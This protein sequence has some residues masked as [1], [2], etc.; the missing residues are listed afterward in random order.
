MGMEN[1]KSVAIDIDTWQILTD[2]AEQECRS[3]AMQIKWLVRNSSYGRATPLQ[4]PAPKANKKGYPNPRRFD[5]NTRLNQVLKMLFTSGATLCSTDFANVKLGHTTREASGELYA[6]M[7]RG[8]VKK[9]N[10]TPPFYYQITTQGEK[11]CRDMGF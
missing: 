9:V 11:R 4:L 7:K 1:H 2:A 5:P 6:L 3:V 8:D 10:D